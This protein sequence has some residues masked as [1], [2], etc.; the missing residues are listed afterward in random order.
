MKPIT[1]LLALATPLSA[2]FR[3]Q[4][5]DDKVTIGYGLA[6]ADVDGDGKQ[7]I[8]LVDSAETVWYQNPT[9]QK[10][11]LTG[12]LTPKDHVCVCAKDITGDGKAEIAVGAE[13]APNDTKDSGAVFALF[14]GA[15]RNQPWTHKTLHR[16][17]TTHRMHWVLEKPGVNFL[18]VLPLHGC[19]NVK[20]EGPGIKFFGY[21]PETDASKDWATFLLHEGFHMAHNFDPV[22]WEKG[23]PGESL[24]VACKEGTHLLQQ[25]EGKW[26]ATRLSEKGSGEVRTGKLPGGKR[27]ITTIE[28]MHGNEV[29]V[30]SESERKSWDENRIL[31]DDTLN[32]GHALAAADFLGLGYDQIAAGW[33]EPSKDTKKVGIKLYA[34]DGNGWKTHSLVDDN[35]MAC[36]D[37]KAADLNG[38]GKP[39]LI[40][41]GRATKN[42]II[43]WNE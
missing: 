36:E 11:Q 21:R 40:A 24:L 16:E 17:P 19:D 14:P 31:L 43:Y 32:Q 29:A 7:D 9:W 20:G 15:D 13:W 22:T 2:G 41:S 27:F 25:K 8:L 34:A 37:I 1:F 12:K 4:S 33:R 28:P 5:I 30:Y 42:L 23:A 10:R 35:T 18:A 38:D 39:D 6:V 3:P 26:S